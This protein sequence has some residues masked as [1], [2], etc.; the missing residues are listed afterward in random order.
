MRNTCLIIHRRQ[1]VPGALSFRS[2]DRA[3]PL[4]VAADYDNLYSP[5]TEKPVANREKKLN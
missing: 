2:R 1:T 5:E 3:P 4:L